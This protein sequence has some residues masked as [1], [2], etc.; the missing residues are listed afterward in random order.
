MLKC[1]KQV[2]GY[3]YMTI[4]DRIRTLRKNLKWTAQDL[5]NKTNLHPVSIRKYETNK[6]TPQKE[7]IERLATALKVRPY[8][9]S[10]ENYNLV[11]ET[12]G[13]L[14]G[15][16]FML[17]E[18]KLIS[19]K[20]NDFDFVIVELNENIKSF[21]DI[22]QFAKVQ[23]WRTIDVLIN[24]KLKSHTCYSEFLIWISKKEQLKSCKVNEEDKYYLN[25]KNEVEELELILQQSTEKL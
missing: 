24:D 6:M 19:I 25:L 9:I 17:D 14:Y 4:G 23:D 18:I 11:F 20:K 21:L 5:A 1:R 3:E 7:Q 2:K 22:R 15:L 16:L 12:F 10:K 8:T 13:D